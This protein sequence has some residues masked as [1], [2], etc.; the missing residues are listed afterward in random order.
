MK[1]LINTDERLDKLTESV[2]RLAEA[3]KK[4][5]ERLNEL[6][7]AQKRTDERVDKLTNSVDKLVSAVHELRSEVGSLST[8]I[9]F[10]LEDVA[11]KL[12]PAYLEK[13]LKIKIKSELDRKFFKIND[14]EIEINFFGIGEDKFGEIYIIGECKSKMYSG[15]VNKFYNLFKK[16]E[17]SINKRFILFIFGFYIHPTAQDAAK[18]NNIEIIFSY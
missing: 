15:D 13:N 2:N 14:E 17:K 12:V 7:E 4:T 1:D 9:G 18:K 11:R 10:S 5:E 16:I 6:A 3:Q 8:T